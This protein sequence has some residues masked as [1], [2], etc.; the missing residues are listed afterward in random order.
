MSRFIFF[1]ILVHEAT[2]DSKSLNCNIILQVLLSNVERRQKRFFL[3][4][5]LILTS[6]L[7][8]WLLHNS[9]ISLFR[10][11]FYFPFT[12]TTFLLF[13]F[14]SFLI[15]FPPPSRPHS[16]VFLLLISLLSSSSFLLFCLL[17][18]IHHFHV[19]HNASCLHASCIMFIMHHASILHTHCFQFFLGFT[20]VPRE[21]EDNGYAKSFFRGGG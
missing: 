16:I 14:S 3:A 21:P 13:S 20:V 1:L 9:V 15:V 10:H 17:L 5:K 11:F 6:L 19:D 4:I 2:C 8:F 7:P 12:T 18:L